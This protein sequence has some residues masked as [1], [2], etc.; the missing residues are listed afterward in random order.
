[1]KIDKCKFSVPKVEYLGYI[2]T[3]EGI[4]PDPKQNEAVINIERRKYKNKWGSSYVWYNIT[5]IYGQSVVKN[6]HHL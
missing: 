3:Q 4:K 2:I 5:V 1:M 6:W